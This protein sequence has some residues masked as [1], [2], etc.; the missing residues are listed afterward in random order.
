MPSP[1]HTTHD[2]EEFFHELWGVRPF[3]WQ[4]NLVEIVLEKDETVW[5]EAI[6]L[7]TGSGKTACI[8]IAIFALACQAKI[9]A[10]GKA[11]TAPRRTFFVVDRRIIVDEAYLRA[12]R[13]AKKLSQAQ[14]GAVKLVAD[15]LRRVA[16][17][18]ANGYERCKPLTVHLLRGGVFRSETWEH[19]P[20]QPSI[21]TGTVDQIG[22][23][24]LFRSYG[25][26]D[27]IWP[28]HA[29]LAANDSLVFL[30][31]AHCSRPFFQTLQGI[32]RYRTWAEIPLG[33]SFRPVVMSATPPSGVVESNIF[34]D[35]SV[36]GHDP[37]HPLGR[38][39]LA[40]KP[41]K[42][43][44][45]NPRESTPEFLSNSAVKLAGNG[46]KAIVVF[47][48]RI[49]V[50]RETFRKLQGESGL[51]VI[52]L[53]GRMRGF[54]QEFQAQRMRD[55]HLYS[56][57]ST[58]RDLTQPV[59]V[60]ATQTLEVGADLDFDGL[61]T[62][63]A[64]LDALRQRF[65][66]LNRMGRDIDCRAEILLPHESSKQED[67][68]YGP[69]LVETAEWLTSQQNEESEVD[70]GIAHFDR[71]VR[72]SSQLDRLSK[73]APDAPVMLPAHVDCW[74]Q[75]SP[76]PKPTPDVSVFLHGPEERQ[77]DVQVCWRA[78][79]E[80]SHLENAITSLQLC[81]PSSPELMP[82]PLGFFRRWLSS[83]ESQKDAV[84]TSAD[85]EGVDDSILADISDST[86][87]VLCWRGQH[88]SI[89]GTAK[90]IRPG[91]IVV[92]PVHSPK[93]SSQLGDLP[94]DSPWDSGDQA[95][96]RTRARA[97]LRLHPR[98]VGGWPEDLFATEKQLALSLLRDIRQEYEH[99][100]EEF[101]E[102][103]LEVLGALANSNPDPE[104]K[105]L[106]ENARALRREYSSLKK[107]LK[108]LQIVGDESLVLVGATKNPN[109]A[110][111]LESLGDFSDEHDETASGISHQDGTPVPLR[112]HLSGV[113]D[114]ARRHA[115]GCGLPG[116]LVNAIGL[117]GLLHDL[118]KADPRFQSLLRGGSPWWG[119]ELL[120][121]SAQFCKSKEGRASSCYPKGGRHELLS[122]RLAESVPELLPQ[123]EDLRDLVL[124]L[125][126]SH[127]GYCRPFAPVVFDDSP[128]KVDLDIL[129]GHK[130]HWEGPT[131]LERVDSGVSERFWRLTRKYGWWGL[132][133]IE[134]LL[135]TADWRR[136][137]WEESHAG[138]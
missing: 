96:I 121:K 93:D 47:A 127:H 107:L 126:A 25:R 39:Q 51:Q 129:L 135:R 27:R 36:E 89:P 74:V 71:L 60:V 53:T 128:I 58:E 29:G 33:R 52:L 87:Q 38:R 37:G 84:D 63:C 62:E 22:S 94:S 56:D 92:I 77:A 73:P 122:V 72:A 43:R 66:R 116:E 13:L 21:I 28:I 6:D 7:P 85:I 34:R 95:H 97:I 103:V 137:A 109:L 50:A 78:D 44:K 2:F 99:A 24:L 16:H 124:H 136:S 18:A 42:L 14:G 98:I 1:Q 118:G 45:L 134:A 80:V 112:N 61:V 130:M 88:D 79:I 106:N 119:G 81:P 15:N 68:V 114:F 83:G 46:S 70:F 111:D 117:A 138:E 75:T 26:R 110:K 48:N 115:V 11:V 5:P 133:W 54:D 120:A 67:P 105:W 64:S 65:G 40:S 113:E 49:N 86:Y 76:Q 23:R 131:S 125:V 55:M 9:L 69:A 17:G 90:D 35:T 104:W 32:A 102:R 41:A 4:R 91:E 59:I 3:A 132:A 19:D 82:V 101:A 8:D 20:L 10:Q 108:A 31:E 100:P 123:D 30:D 57:Q 12:R